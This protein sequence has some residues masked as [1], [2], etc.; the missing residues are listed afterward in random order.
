MNSRLLE[1]EGDSWEP[2]ILLLGWWQ[3]LGSW[4]GDCCSPCP[5]HGGVGVPSA[6]FLSLGDSY[7]V[8]LEGEKWLCELINKLV[9]S[10]GISSFPFSIPQ[11]TGCC[12]LGTPLGAASQQTWP[13][14]QGWNSGSTQLLLAAGPGC[15]EPE[16]SVLLKSPELRCNSGKALDYE[17]IISSIFSRHRV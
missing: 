1:L 2:E 5:Q 12:C 17:E 10:V 7:L 16:N 11:V 13:N 4:R 3:L 8:F 15:P 14:E 9:G 6:L